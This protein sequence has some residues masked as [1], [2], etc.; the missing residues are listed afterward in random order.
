MK[1][2]ASILKTV[3]SSIVGSSATGS[4]SRSSSHY[5][6]AHGLLDPKYFIEEYIDASLHGQC[7]GATRRH[8]H[9]QASIAITGIPSVR[10]AYEYAMAIC[11]P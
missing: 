8:S 11:K 1:H 7:D 10:I 6:D 4:P 2:R 3:T 5:S 9:T